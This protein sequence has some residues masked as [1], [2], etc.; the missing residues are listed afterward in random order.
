MN[1]RFYLF[2]GVNFYLNNTI[3]S[4]ANGSSSTNKNYPRP[5]NI[6]SLKQDFFFVDNDKEAVD[7]LL[8]SI[9][10]DKK[11]MCTCLK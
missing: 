5:E 1:L 10:L 4:T 7:D 6:E 9:Y 3:T 2:Q 8:N 11:S